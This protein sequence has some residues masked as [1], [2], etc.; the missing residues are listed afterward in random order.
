MTSESLVSSMPNDSQLMSPCSLAGVPP[1]GLKTNALCKYPLVLIPNSRRVQPTLIAMK[2]ELQLKPSGYQSSTTAGDAACSLDGIVYPAS[3]SPFPIPASK[4]SA[5]AGSGTGAATATATET[6]ALA[7]A[8]A[9]S[10]INPTSVNSDDLS[11]LS[12]TQTST[13][14]LTGVALTNPVAAAA[15]LN[16]PPF[17]IPSVSYG[18]GAGG[19][20]LGS[21]TG[22]GQVIKPTAAFTGGSGRV[23]PAILL[24][25]A[26]V[27]ALL[28]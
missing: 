6:T 3:G 8:T 14:Y 21:G 27:L 24:M 1:G 4:Q 9:I 25:A 17:P 5:A 10:P 12:S 13:E 15:T 23:Y 18:T 26:G 2:F 20:V 19:V 7:T 22:T 16:N 28:L 11:F